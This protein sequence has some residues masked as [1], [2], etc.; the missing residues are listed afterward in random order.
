VWALAIA[1]ASAR[2]ATTG[3]SGTRAFFTRGREPDSGSAVDPCRMTFLPL[4]W[5][6]VLTGPGLSPPGSFIFSA[7]YSERFQ[8][9][10]Q[11]LF[12]ARF[13]RW[14]GSSGSGRR[15]LASRADGAGADGAGSALGCTGATSLWRGWR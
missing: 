7:A 1:L 8:Q 14:S 15:G 3:A 9:P 11:M 5:H 2:H 6:P 13:N 12:R 10:R 4:P